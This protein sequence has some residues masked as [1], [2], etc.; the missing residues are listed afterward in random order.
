MY[1]FLLTFFLLYGAMHLYAFLKAR[2]AIA[3][4]ANT[5]IYL[6]LFMTV[7][8]FSPFIIRFSERLELNLF[9]R[10]MSYI[11]Y[12]WMGILFLFFSASVCM[13]IYRLMVYIAGSVFH[14]NLSSLIPSA[15][16]SFYLP[17]IL[18]V[19]IGIYGYFE[20]LNIRTEKVSIKTSKI[21]E[22]IGRLRIVQISD[23]HIGLIIKEERL[24]RIL[25]EVKKADPDIIVSTGDLVDG[26]VDGLE[27]LAE[28]FKEINPKHGKFAV[29]GNH[30]FY[31]GL[32]QAMGFTEKAGF[33]VL[34]GEGL[35]V[36]G[37]I[38]IAG[39]DDPAGKNYNLYHD[40]S[41]RKLL[42]QMP[43]DKFTLLLKHRPVVDKDSSGLFDLQL[44]GHAHKGQIFP[45]SL[46]T[47]L[48]YRHTVHAGHLRLVDDSYLYVSRGAGTW[49]PPIRFLSPPEVTVI[50]LVSQ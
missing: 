24:K 22:G 6:I 46:L 10:F 15:R 29:T 43:R 17:V 14:W 8:V 23:V 26:Q 18:S 33:K 28:L 2:A 9:A 11:S 30:E 37:L 1:I 47:W 13:D 50:E 39:V 25:E 20:A 45:F 7:M 36:A 27:G 40:I 48:Y 49:G 41:G 38:N 44:S 31:A 3:F 12:T 35:T 19:I 4:S 5:G 34:R 32:G 16:L 21:P 42:S